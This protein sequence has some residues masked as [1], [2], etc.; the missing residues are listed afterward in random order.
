MWEQ[1]EMDFEKVMRS[2]RISILI[3]GASRE[4]FCHLLRGDNTETATCEPA[5]GPSPEMKSTSTNL[6]SQV[7]L[8]TENWVPGWV[9][10][11]M[12]YFSTAGAKS[13]LNIL[14]ALSPL[15]VSFVVACLLFVF[16]TGS[17]SQKS[18]VSAPKCSII[19]SLHWRLTLTSPWRWPC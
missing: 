19:P 10:Q 3:K 13:G 15:I 4:L 18:P 5:G 11:S 2:E 7:A 8:R 9:T 14:H 12:A 1:Q 16:E 6:D 17:H